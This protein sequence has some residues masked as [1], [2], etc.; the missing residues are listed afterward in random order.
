VVVNPWLHFVHLHEL[1]PMEFL[2]DTPVLYAPRYSP[3]WGQ[4]QQLLSWD[5]LKSD[6][7]WLQPG[8]VQAG[9]AAIIFTLI[10]VNAIGLIHLLKSTRISR[11]RLVVLPLAMVVLAGS[12][13][14]STL[15]HYFERDLQFGP[16]DDA[17]H[18]ILDRLTM[19]GRPG[20]GIVTLMTYHYHVPMNVY[21][22]HL[23]VYGFSQM[24]P[25]LPPEGTRLLQNI[26][27]E[28]DRIWLVASGI[29]PGESPNEVEKWLAE[30][31]FKATDEWYDDFRLCLYASSGTS[32]VSDI[33]QVPNTTLG[34]AIRLGSYKISPTR[35]QAGE[36]LTIML[37]WQVE[38]EELPDY[39]VFIH[40]IAPDGTLAA[41]Q[42]SAPVGGFRPTSTW[43]IGEV[44]HDRH[45]LLLPADIEP[46]EYALWTGLYDG[47]TGE[48]LPVRL[49]DGNADD[50]ILLGTVEVEAP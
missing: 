49:P 1:F 26:T 8:G 36:M 44:I 33:S 45:G 19:E 7:A 10:I 40:L 29:R 39:T 12:I 35:Q 22:G 15:D 27:E 13:S 30:Q 21:K 24:A 2:E 46:G 25:P 9:I 48:R 47:A 14:L 3:V 50:H 5:T 23:P 20:D 42:D 6:I 16:P 4:V 41:Q 38:R 18:R 43:S 28:H 34:E 17:L 11:G 32:E 31:T 37:N